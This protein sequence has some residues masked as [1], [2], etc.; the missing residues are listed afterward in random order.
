MKI[1]DTHQ[2]LI[3]PERLSYSWTRDVPA[4]AD[5]PFRLEEYRQGAAGTGI[6]ETLFMEVAVDGPQMKA[7]ADFFLSLAGKPDSGIVGV[8]AT[9]RPEREDFPVYLESILHPRLRGLRR[10]LHTE[11]DELSQSSL[12]ARNVGNLAKHQLTYDLCLRARQ[13]H[14]GPGLLRQIPGVQVV[15]DHCG[16][17]NVKDG[18]LDPWRERVRELSK[19]SN[20]ACKISGVVAYCGPG[21]VTAAKIRPFVEH[22]IECFGWERVLFGGDW[23]VCNLTS[24]LGQWV[25]I[26]RELVA[27]ESAERQAA[28]FAGNAARIYRL[29]S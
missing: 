7:E 29:A 22:C 21:E 15:L 10:V 1:I 25:G 11:P 14:L 26:A 20:L 6:S 3:Y 27:A 5:K 13:L 17:P 19:F 2:H 28:F 12:F 16:I 9:C 24:S 23:P 4:L 8:V 18:E